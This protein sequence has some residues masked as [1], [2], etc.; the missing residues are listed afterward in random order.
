MAL[1][2][3]ELKSRRIRED[4]SGIIFG[5]KVFRVTTSGDPEN[6]KD[7]AGIPRLNDRWEVGKP[8]VDIFATKIKCIP[9]T[10]SNM[11]V[12]VVVEY[13]NT[14]IGNGGS[15]DTERATYTIS[16]KLELETIDLDGSFI[17]PCNSL[18]VNLIRPQCS[19]SRLALVNNLN[20]YTYDLTTGHANADLYMGAKPGFIRFMGMAN[21]VKYRVAGALT[22]W[23]VTFNFEYCS[24]RIFGSVGRQ[25]GDLNYW[26]PHQLD[27]IKMRD[28]CERLRGTLTPCRTVTLS[29]L[30]LSKPCSD[31]VLQRTFFAVLFSNAKFL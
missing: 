9:S 19:F 11:I 15:G 24:K 10:S 22:Q 17:G 28:E 4:V 18:G 26:N 23:L 2:P 8:K 7:E 21:A 5:Q 1:T 30:G 16:P 6:A 29:S 25:P 13:H 12:D 3:I 27:S 20:P 14:I 31:R